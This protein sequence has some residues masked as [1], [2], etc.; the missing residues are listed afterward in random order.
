M[1]EKYTLRE[2]M[3]CAAAREISDG[4][5]VFVGMRLPLIAFVLAKKVNAPNAIGLFENGIIRSTPSPSLIYTMGDPPNLIGATYTGEMLSVMAYLQQGKVAV[6][7]LGGAEV[8]RYGNLNST[9]VKNGNNEIRLPG[10]GGACDIASLAKKVLIIMNHEKHRFVEKVN[11][12]TSPGYG[13]GGGW[14]KSVGLMRGG[15]AAVISTKGIFDF[16]P[17]GLMQVRTIHPGLTANELRDAT[18]FELL[19]TDEVSETQPPS[20]EELRV[21]R[22]YDPSGFWTGW[23]PKKSGET[24]AGQ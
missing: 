16:S 8:D 4:D 5:I 3:I 1:E 13:D 9:I 7:F 12:I 11:Y 17:D 22:E 18:G 23:N 21:I 10:S 24:D 14:R 6:G 19:M 15:P 20:E 2:L